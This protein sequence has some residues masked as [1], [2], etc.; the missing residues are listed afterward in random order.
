[1]LGPSWKK[2]A[3]DY[4]KQKIKNRSKFRKRQRSRPS[5]V[6][7][8]PLCMRTSQGEKRKAS[9]VLCQRDHLHLHHMCECINTVKKQQIVHQHSIRF[10]EYPNLLFFTS[11]RLGSA[12]LLFGLSRR[13]WRW[14]PNPLSFASG[15]SSISGETFFLRRPFSLL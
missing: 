4:T 5:A 14:F 12:L 6:Q 1:M 10:L 7:T 2:E 8:G 3:I 11:S 15:R 13:P 9:L